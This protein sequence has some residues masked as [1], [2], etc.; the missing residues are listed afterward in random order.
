MACNTGVYQIKNIITGDIYIGSASRISKYKSASGFNVRFDKHLRQLRNNT[1]YNRF[2]QN[3]FNK[4]KEESFIFEV[5]ATCPSEYCIKLEQFFLDVLKPSFNIR[6]IADSNKGV[7]FTDEHKEKIRIANLKEN[8]PERGIKISLAKT[9]V[10]RADWVKDKL[11]K[12]KIGIPKSESGKISNRDKRRLHKSIAKLT[13]D[14]VR[15]IKISLQNNKKATD[16][17]KQY[18]VSISCIMDIKHNRTFKD[19]I[20]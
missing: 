3:S 1:H 10:K 15:D 14:N 5:L 9:G 13:V 2:L 12:S 7:R 19:I 16:L 17:A 20:I 11:S 6:T 4:Y 18:N 8:N